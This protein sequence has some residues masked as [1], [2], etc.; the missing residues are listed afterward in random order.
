MSKNMDERVQEKINEIVECSEIFK[1]QSEQLNESKKAL[2]EA[3]RIVEENF[4]ES[5]KELQE[6]TQR[7]E[8]KIEENITSIYS[9][10]SYLEDSREDFKKAANLLTRNM[11]DIVVKSDVAVNRYNDLLEKVSRINESCR[12]SVDLLKKVIN[13]GVWADFNQFEKTSQLPEKIQSLCDDLINLKADIS[14][15]VSKKIAADMASIR[16][17]QAD[18]RAFM[19]VK[20][21]ELFKMLETQSIQ[22]TEQ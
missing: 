12:A 9:A 7:L 15:E 10:K 13:Q 22:G 5:R 4:D 18:D 20:F 17:Q 3:K 1:S 21:A 14:E 8:D 11:E 2:K 16:A 19:E 6:A